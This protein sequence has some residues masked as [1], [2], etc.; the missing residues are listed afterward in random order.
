MQALQEEEYAASL[1]ANLELQKIQNEIAIERNVEKEKEMEREDMMMAKKAEE[2]REQM[3]KQK[4]HDLQKWHET[5]KQVLD[6]NMRE[7]YM[8]LARER[9]TSHG[10]CETDRDMRKKQKCI[11]EHDERV[12]QG[13]MDKEYAKKQKKMLDESRE[14][15]K[16]EQTQFEEKKSLEVDNGNVAKS[17]AGERMMVMKNGK[18]EIVASSIGGKGVCE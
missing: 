16:A 12:R 11:M 6:S 18:W 7:R 4:A 13:E 3:E 17:M 14:R 2:R 8:D 5:E 15:K 9:S 1:A 10:G